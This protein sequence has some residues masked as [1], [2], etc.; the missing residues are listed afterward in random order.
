MKLKDSGLKLFQLLILELKRL[1]VFNGRRW[2]DPQAL[3]VARVQPL[4]SE[5]II[6]LEI[7]WFA[8]DTEDTGLGFLMIGKG[9]ADGSIKRLPTDNL[10]D[11]QGQE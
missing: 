9:E 7:S 11:V 2:Y 5:V 6:V 8:A 1:G 10:V 3:C 4:L